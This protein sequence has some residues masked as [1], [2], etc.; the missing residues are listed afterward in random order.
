M[1]Q[2]NAFEE[3]ERA[4]ADEIS[5]IDL[6]APVF[7]HKWFVV[8]GTIIVAIAALAYQLV[9]LR[10]PSE[11]SYLPNVYKPTAIMFVNGQESSSLSSTLAASGLSSIAGIAGISSGTSYGRLAVTIAKSNSVIDALVDKFG[12]IE[13]Y[14]ITSSPRSRS[15]GLILN[16]YNANL[17]DKTGLLSISYEDRDPVFAQQLVN[18]AVELV[19]ERFSTIGGNKNIA[20]RD[21]L[22]SKLADVKA[23]MN[24]L[25]S[26]IQK[27][28]QQ[29]GILTTDSIANEQI[30]T[31]AKIRS[32]L[33]MKEMEIKTYG[34]M[35]KVQDPALAQLVAERD[36]LSKL[37]EE[38]EK[39]YSEYEK[40]LPTNKELPKLAIDFSHLQRDLAVQEKIYEL[41][42][43]Q[44]ELTK[45][46]ITG[47]DPIIQI[48]EPA[49][50]P[51]MKS[52][53]NRIRFCMIA[54]VG[55]FFV[56]ILLAFLIEAIRKI[57]NDPV[58]LEKIRGGFADSSP[59]VD[60]CS[61][62]QDK[63]E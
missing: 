31:V 49:E 20:K 40:V 10:L 38:L 33:I 24:R 9:A 4:G 23:E 51:D 29:H 13:K 11:K 32:E 56:F 54:S 35:S 52:G 60:S 44:Y 57:K 41:L 27:F 43:Q 61:T 8:F 6:L 42:T 34:N 14:K 18:Y 36:N 63:F 46:Q 37:L 48:L 62:N 19:G 47:S 12:I 30:S 2:K 28:Q 55:A 45:L 15:R 7:A 39:G 58:A 1:G 16:N 5:F 22:E 50:V 21:Q 25:E 26:E 17:D 3:I 59:V 53:P